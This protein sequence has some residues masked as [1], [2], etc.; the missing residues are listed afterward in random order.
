VTERGS[1]I[2]RMVS[3]CLLFVEQIA[4]RA[5]ALQAQ[6]VTVDLV[7]QQPVRFDMRI[8]EAGPFALERVIAVLW[9]QRITLEQ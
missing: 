1:G 7:E 3:V 8:P 9:G 4:V 6:H 2:A 5:G